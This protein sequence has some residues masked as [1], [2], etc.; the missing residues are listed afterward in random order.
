MYGNLIGLGIKYV[1]PA[2]AVIGLVTWFGYK[3][4]DTGRDVERAV[5]V[6]RQADADM[7]SSMALVAMAQEHQYH[8]EEIRNEKKTA[9]KKLELD[10]A[11]VTDRGLYVSAQACDGASA[12]AADTDGVGGASSRQRLHKETERNLIAL[13]E[14]ADKLVI[15]YEGCVTELL[16]H[17]TLIPSNQPGVP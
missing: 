12:Q 15:Q 4:Y 10:V 13:V 11:R 8:L 1:L 16:H 17:T 7:E 9:V 14:E 2:L 6:E 3:A 5:W